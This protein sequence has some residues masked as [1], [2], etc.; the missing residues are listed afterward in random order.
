M[1]IRLVSSIAGCVAAVA[2]YS[3]NPA[4]A[5]TIG[6]TGVTFTLGESPV[7][8]GTET[9]SLQIH[10]SPPA[11]GALGNGVFG[12]IDLEPGDGQLFAINVPV[13]TSAGT[14]SQQ[15]TYIAPGTYTPSYSFVGT[16]QET[17]NFGYTVPDN[18]SINV[19][20]DFAQVTISAVPEPSTWAMMLLGF[21]GIGFMA[22]RR[23]SKA[24]F[25]AA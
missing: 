11:N 10:L 8:N 7:V 20:G 9:F 2:L 1:N 12:T 16:A 4:R 22:Y 5:S 18:E 24:A 13:G 14:F 19:S 3:I 17:A 6:V 21:A 25:M 15:V 23:K